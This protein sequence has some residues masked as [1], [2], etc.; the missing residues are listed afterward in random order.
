MSERTKL[1]KQKMPRWIWQLRLPGFHVQLKKYLRFLW[2]Q[3]PEGCNWSRAVR[4][5]YF[6]RSIGV[7]TRWDAFLEKQ[8]L[9][10][11]SK[12][13]TMEHRIG[14]RPYYS[15]AAWEAKLRE[16]RRPKARR[17]GA[18]PYTAQQKNSTKYY[19]SSAAAAFQPS[20][21]PPVARE[22][23]AP[24]E[25]SSQGANP[26]APPGGSGG[27]S[28]KGMVVIEPELRSRIAERIP[29]GQQGDWAAEKLRS[30]HIDELK[31]FAIKLVQDGISEGDAV[32]QVLEQSKAANSRKE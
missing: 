12:K 18:P 8:H 21:E 13:G 4:G 1:T 5:R 6:D 29:R 23:A 20:A 31:E 10:W 22:P 28:A 32:E 14:A 2:R 25:S 11:V 26:P 7:I 16:S 17:A 19:S 15:R 3:R 9:V 27:P 24:K 30:R